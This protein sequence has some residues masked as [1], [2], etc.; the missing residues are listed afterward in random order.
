MTMRPPYIMYPA[1]K[2]ALPA[3]ASVPAFIT[4]PGPRPHVAVDDD[5]RPA[6]RHPG[7]RAR[8]SPHHD[9][10]AV[11]VVADAPADIVVDLE[12]GGVGEPGAEVAGRA[13][14]AHVDRMHQPHTEVVAGVRIDE[15][16]VGA[17]GAV[18]AYELVRLANRGGR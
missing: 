1:M 3:Q 6:N 11:H 9:L 7:N 8:V 14:D 12:A 4:C 15:L 10:A 2:L 18:L 13:A 17:V 16:D 5:L